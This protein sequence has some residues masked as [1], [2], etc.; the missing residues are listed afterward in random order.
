AARAGVPIII[1]HIHGPS[2]GPF[3]GTFA[4]LFFTAA[5]RRAGKVTSYFICSASAMAKRYLAADIGTPEMYTRI[6]SGFQMEPFLTAKND[7]GL[8]ARLGLTEHDFIIGKIAR[9]APLKGPEE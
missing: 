6:F 2:F 9:L 3:Q 7:P 5:E 4:N 1:H 8:R